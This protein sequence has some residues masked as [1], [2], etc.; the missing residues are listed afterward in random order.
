MSNLLLYIVTNV[1]NVL[2][3]LKN[4]QANF[5]LLTTLYLFKFKKWSIKTKQTILGLMVP[6]P[7]QM[8]MT[9]NWFY[10]HTIPES[11]FQLH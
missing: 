5:F 6:W 8:D 10:A 2:N 7:I 4:E 1:L 11:F 3:V 9:F